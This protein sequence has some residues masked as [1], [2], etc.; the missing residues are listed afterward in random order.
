M[1]KT[2]VKHLK[3]GKIKNIWM[4]IQIFLLLIFESDLTRIRLIQYEVIG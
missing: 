4:K 2:G 3:P 1:R